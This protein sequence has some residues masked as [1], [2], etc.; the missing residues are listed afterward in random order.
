MKS[1]IVY[2]EHAKKEQNELNCEQKIKKKSN[3]KIEKKD[4]KEKLE[5]CIQLIGGSY[6]ITRRLEHFIYSNKM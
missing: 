4:G 1:Q 5:I 6:L 2:D 3:W